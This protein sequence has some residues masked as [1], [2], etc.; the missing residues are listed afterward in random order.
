MN[1]VSGHLAILAGAGVAAALLALATYVGQRME[2]S[3]SAQAP[4]VVTVPPRPSQLRRQRRPP[5]ASLRRAT[6]GP[7]DP[8]SLA[9]QLQS[10]LKRVGCYDGEISG[11]WSPRTRMAMKAFTDRVNAT[12]RSTSPT[13]SCWLSCKGIR[14]LPA[15][16]RRSWPRL[17]PNRSR[18]RS[19]RRKSRSPS[20]PSCRRSP[21]LPPS[22]C[23]HLAVRR[24]RLR[25]SRQAA[26]VRSHAR[27]AAG[28]GT[29]R[30][31]SRA[32][33]ASAAQ[34]PPRRTGAGGWHLRAPPA[35][36][37]PPLSTGPLCARA[38]QKPEAGRDRCR[39]V[40]PDRLHAT[41]C[42]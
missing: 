24:L 30:P 23:R 28:A 8:T 16:P 20:R 9:R 17:R 15:P 37:R 21:P 33:R 5:R 29:G 25:S 10:E 40:F 13:T 2:T 4:V 1:N 38:A 27:A 18:P 36:L 7:Q 3:A 19:T 31:C 32:G 6:A 11:V 12:C 26:R 35:P 41:G 42:A 34:P 14:A 39:G 22:S